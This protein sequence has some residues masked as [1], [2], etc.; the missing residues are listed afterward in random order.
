MFKS[1]IVNRWI[2]LQQGENHS[3]IDEEPSL[4]PAYPNQDTVSQHL[5]EMARFAAMQIGQRYAVAVMAHPRTL[6][7]VS[8][9]VVHRLRGGFAC[10]LNSM[11]KFI[12]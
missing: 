8:N 1:E 11:R 10:S 5:C 3:A 12:F 6:Y 2:V 9:S 7:R 4:K